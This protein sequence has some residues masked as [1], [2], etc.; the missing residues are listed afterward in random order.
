MRKALIFQAI[1][2]C[3]VSVLVFALKGKQTRRE[4]D[5]REAGRVGPERTAMEVFT[6]RDMVGQSKED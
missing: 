3:V 1:I 6:P 5:E 2:I 4:R